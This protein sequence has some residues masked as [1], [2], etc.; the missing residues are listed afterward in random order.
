MSRKRTTPSLGQGEI[1]RWAGSLGAVSAEALAYRMRVSVASARAR[2]VVARREGWLARWRPLAGQPV[3][4]TA[5]AAGLRACG[6]R[7]IEPARVSAAGAMH[8]LTCAQVAAA[9]ERCYPDYRVLGEREMRRDERER[10]HPLASAELGVGAHGESL[11]HRCDLVLWPL[12]PDDGLPVAVEVELT[13]KA[14]VRL[15][16]ICRA[17]ARCRRV[18]GVLYIVAPS[19]ERALTRAVDRARARERIVIVG[20]DALPWHGGPKEGPVESTVPGDA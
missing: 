5:T 13:V 17:W 18:A 19:V 14:P 10:G 1:I 7:G 2:L 11:L 6:A 4:Y 16:A 8:L 9:L 15:T 3:L 20:L 12:A